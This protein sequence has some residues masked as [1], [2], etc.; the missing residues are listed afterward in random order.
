MLNC[1]VSLLDFTFGTGDYVAL[2]AKICDL[3]KLDLSVA[4]WN[5]AA[6]EL[7]KKMREVQFPLLP[8]KAVAKT[9]D[10]TREFLKASF[11]SKAVLGTTTAAL[12]GLSAGTIT[13]GVATTFGTAGTGAAISS[14]SGAAANSAMLAWLGGGT[15]A[16]GGGGVAAGS[17]FL[18]MFMTGGGLLAGAAASYGAYKLVQWYNQPQTLTQALINAKLLS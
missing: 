9:I 17:L 18:G 11:P 14:L 16:A 3:Q 13:T 6:N 8:P 2:H 7:V 12:V 1:I 4:S 5:E 15:V 10:A